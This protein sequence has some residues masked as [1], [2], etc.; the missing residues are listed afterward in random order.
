MAYPFNITQGGRY[1][2]FF[3]ATLVAKLFIKAPKNTVENSHGNLVKIKLHLSRSVQITSSLEFNVNIKLHC[4]PLGKIK[5]C[6]T[7]FLVMASRHSK[8]HV[9]RK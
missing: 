8:I 5:F 6:K 7:G 4:T 9:G 3:S 2:R 1:N